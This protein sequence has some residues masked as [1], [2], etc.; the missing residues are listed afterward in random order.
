MNFGP[1]H[2]VETEDDDSDLSEKQRDER[3]ATRVKSRPGIV[4]LQVIGPDGKAL[5]GI[6]TWGGMSLEERATACVAALFAG[7]E[8]DPRIMYYDPRARIAFAVQPDPNVRGVHKGTGR[9]VA[10]TVEEALA[11]AL[12]AFGMRAAMVRA[13]IKRRK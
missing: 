7:F 3:E 6:K 5:P 1:S 13:F 9:A 2:L 10:R 4:G 11:P 8:L 12:A